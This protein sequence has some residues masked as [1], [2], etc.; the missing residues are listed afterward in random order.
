VAQVNSRALR[1]SH[2]AIASYLAIAI[3]WSWPLPIHLAD[4]FT[5]DP[6]DPLLNTYLI[7]WNAQAV[8]LTAAYWSPPFYWPLRNTLALSEHLAGLW[9]ITTPL[10]LLGAS[11]LFAYN[12]VILASTWWTGLATH[13]LTKRLTASTLAAY[14]A[15]IAFAFAPY[16]TSQ[17]AH[18][19]LYACWWIPVMLLA[20]HAY[21]E[22]R[23]VR[24]LVLLCVA[25]LLQGLTNGYYLLFLPVLVGA[26]ILWF[27]TIGAPPAVAS[28][29]VGWPAVASAKV[30]A[31]WRVLL[32]LA[33]SLGLTLPFLLQ[34][35]VVH[36][37]QGL[38]RN[39]GEM[40]AYSARPESLLSATPILRFW[41][42]RPPHT[43]EQY[44]FPGLTALALVVAGVVLA[45]KD[46]RYRFYTLAA[47]LM[48]L[49]SAGPAASLFSIET[50]WH[51][52]TFL[53]ALPGFSGLRVPTRFFMLA[54]LCLAVAA[55]LSF[56]AIERRFPRRRAWLAVIVFA[57]LAVDGAIAGMP[58]GVPP[59]QL[60]VPEA[61]ARVLALPF[62][63][64]R[65]SVYAMYQSM[66]H[67]RPV[68]NG[69]SGY[70][71]SHAD[72]IE[73]ALRRRDPTVLTELRRGH[74]LYVLVAFTDQA[75]QWTEF[76]D[77]QPD[78][79]M[80]GIEGGGRLY[81]MPPTAYPREVRA[82]NPIADAAV[83]IEGDWLMADVRQPRTVRSIELRTH[84][85]LLR[86]P[87]DLRI[88][89]SVD[90]TQWELAFE[91]RPGGLALV[92]ALLLPRVIPLRVD[93]KDA[94]ARYVR[95]NVAAFGTAA[96]F[97]YGS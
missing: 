79:T 1:S 3:V 67:R 56:A 78:A 57:G 55:G 27:T 28:A 96:M 33:V 22:E 36:R 29:K 80:L 39:L 47:I 53:T 23:R 68:V 73:W 50:L 9:P 74:P 40:A 26:W 34:Y 66:A 25:Y 52:Y 94:T 63:E 48:A 43:T 86:L 44:L 13:A 12:L 97:I 70:V 45:R 88:E 8:P 35:Y 32:T 61:G 42:T 93:L 5:H 20:L 11:P 60:V 15:G 16:R 72:V 62:E 92:G 7:W 46:G 87:R 58:L 90:G 85:K 24:W 18:I 82:G 41:N 65:V 30:G 59:S 49:L 91:E 81:R 19:Q 21:Y 83:T 64:G 17:L 31:A 69:Y 51:P 10:Q 14:C 2:I 84:G 38:S 75:A 89:T 71:T 95:V 6:G 37:D 76:M 77:Q 54:V 4:R